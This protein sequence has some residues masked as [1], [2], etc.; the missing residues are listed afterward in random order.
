[1]LMMEYRHPLAALRRASTGTSHALMSRT[2]I[3]LATFLLAGSGVAF[4]QAADWQ[5]VGSPG[6]TPG[7]VLSCRI[8]FDANDV[9]YVAYQDGGLPN[10]RASVQ[11]FIGG[12]WEYVG[13]QGGASLGDAWYNQIAFDTQGNLYVTNRD[14]QLNGRINV[15]RY[16]AGGGAWASLGIQGF[17]ALDAHYTSIALRSDGVPFVAYAD[18]FTTPIDRAS[19]MSFQNGIWDFVGVWGTS[20]NTAGFETIAIAPDGTPY[21]GFSDS[22]HVDAFNVGKATVMRYDAGAGTWSY[23][24][25]PGYSVR[26][27]GNMAI[28]IDSLGGLWSAYHEFHQRIVVHHFDGQRWNEVG[29]SA[30]AGDHPTI[31]TE[32]W[33]QW[34]SLCFDSQNR[35]YV[36]YQLFDGGLK[37]AVRR[38]DG[39]NWVPVGTIG[40]SPAGSH[41][42]ALGIDKKDVP[43]VVFR[44]EANG[45][46]MSVMR[47]APS[48]STYCTAKIN[49]Q[50][51]IPAIAAG[52][53][54]SL[55]STAPFVVAASQVINRRTG[56]LLYGTGPA[57]QPFF[58]GVLCIAPPLLRTPAQNSG[59]SSGTTDC[60]GT[61]AID[62][63][64]F[65]QSGNFG[66]FLPG[67]MIFS[68]YWSRDSGDPQGIGLTDAVR[69]TIV[70]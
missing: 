2:L 17:S 67:E 38:Y 49:S 14:Y 10:Y 62:L 51:C 58:G 55:S 61:Y 9:P 36:A 37:A 70:P 44:D 5:F 25:A 1:M 11:R 24:G 69:A 48:P 34:I 20:P 18:R 7:T 32:G 43:Y 23:V 15:R 3:A 64:P 45:F 22:D 47:Y 59:G 26:G 56:M 12:Q 63:N 68:Q 16:P 39:T 53:D 46:R 65:L 31:E 8:T 41:Y 35:P 40:F 54:P 13:A 57:Q 29:G 66:T 19:V 52:G 21:V 27:A 28:A 33:R 4:A 42:M 6:F 30:S 60:S 50:G